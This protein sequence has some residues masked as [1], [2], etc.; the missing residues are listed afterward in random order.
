MSASWTRTAS[1]GCAQSRPA[2]SRKPVRNGVPFTTALFAMD[3]AN[4]IF[5]NVF[6]RDGGFGR[7]AMGGLW[8]HALVIPDL[9]GLSGS[10][11]GRT[12]A[13]G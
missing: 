5:Q 7:D 3:T 8:G 13:A 2:C 1:S 12:N 10:C 6:A 11:H 9:L 4:N